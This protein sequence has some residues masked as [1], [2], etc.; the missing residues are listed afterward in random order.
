MIATDAEGLA[1]LIR[2]LGVTFP[3]RIQAGRTSFSWRDIEGAIDKYH[4]KHPAAVAKA[5]DVAAATCPCH[6]NDVPV[7]GERNP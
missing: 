1:R 4:R 6:S 3:G 7:T 2:D 5:P